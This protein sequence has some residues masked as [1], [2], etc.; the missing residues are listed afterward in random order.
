LTS[1]SRQTAAVI[2][3]SSLALRR[4]VRIAALCELRRCWMSRY[5]MRLPVTVTMITI[6][7]TSDASGGEKEGD[8]FYRNRNDFLGGRSTLA[9]C[10]APLCSECAPGMGRRGSSAVR[11]H[12]PRTGAR[13]PTP[14]DRRGRQAA[15]VQGRRRPR[16][17]GATLRLCFPCVNRK[18]R[19]P[20]PA[21]RA[22]GR[23]A[24]SQ[25]NKVRVSS[26][27]QT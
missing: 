7:F 27:G 12:G 18:P 10:R 4:S 5:C 19:W 8:M 20:S 26:Q 17:A 2:L 15:G 9:I 22:T 16:D 1:A 13:M 3:A 6:R 21:V 14:D 25:F 24:G 23:K 11:A